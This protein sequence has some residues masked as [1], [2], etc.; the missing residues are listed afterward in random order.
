M[1]S[2]E[3]NRASCKLSGVDSYAGEASSLPT[4]NPDFTVCFM[5][6]IRRPVAPATCAC[7]HVGQTRNV[8]V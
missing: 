5:D 8:P 7:R 6:Q 3:F 1:T 2:P 4:G